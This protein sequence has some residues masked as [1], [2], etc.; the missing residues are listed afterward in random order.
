MTGNT[1]FFNYAN[2]KVA[3]ITLIDNKTKNYVLRTNKAN[4]TNIDITSDQVYAKAQGIDAVK[5]DH[6]RKGTLTINLEVFDLKW[7]SILLGGSWVT[8]VT[9]V[10]QTDILKADATNKITLSAEPKTGTLAI[11]KLLEDNLGHDTE[12]TLGEPATNEDTYSITGQEITLNATTAPEGTAFV[13]YYFK[14]SNT[15]AAQLSIKTNVYPGGYTIIGVTEMKAAHNNVPE[16]FEFVAK[17]AS[18]QSQFNLSMEGGTPTSLS[19]VFDL[20]SDE[21]GDMLKITKLGY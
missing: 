16:Y 8:G 5:F 9:D 20:M 12:Q 13:A 10:H 7:M 3:V 15:D 19:I 17:N 18:P 14:D 11:F 6:N 2:T 21:E 4:S 1:G